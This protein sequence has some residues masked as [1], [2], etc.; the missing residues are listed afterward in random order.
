MEISSFKG[1]NKTPQMKCFK[2]IQKIFVKRE[3]PVSL[4]GASGAYQVKDVKNDEEIRVL[5]VD[6][7]TGQSTE[8]VPFTKLE[9][10]SEIATKAEGF[11]RRSVSRYIAD[12]P[13]GTPMLVKEGYDFYSVLL[14]E[15]HAVQLS[16]DKFIAIEMRNLNDMSSY[17]AT[18]QP[19]Y[20]VW[21]FEYGVIAPF[22][23]KYTPMYLSPTELQKD[24]SVG[25]NE[26]VAIP[27]DLI[28]EIQFY[29]KQVDGASPIY[30]R[31][32]L[33]LDQE[34]TNDL[35]FVPLDR[36]SKLRLFG[37]GFANDE[38]ISV[39]ADGLHFGFNRWAVIDLSLFRSFTIRRDAST[40]SFDFFLIDRRPA[41]VT[42]LIT[43]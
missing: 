8:L 26:L 39:S 1:V 10:L 25:E 40:V 34:S 41:E 42:A 12:N 38:F 36:E 11:Q 43:E 35:T 21:G 3:F 18:I 30:T 24:F 6:S 19:V 13:D 28:R 32:E 16:N 14:A 27:I 2:P 29:P 17:P 20:S 7:N 5:L 33:V 9:Y 4:I 31:D 15:E 23:I 22:A 37:G